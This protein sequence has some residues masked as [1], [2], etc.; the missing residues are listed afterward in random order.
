MIFRNLCITGRI[1]NRFTKDMGSVDEI[2]PKIIL[3]SSQVISNINNQISAMVVYLQSFRCLFGIYPHTS[4][5]VFQ[6]ILHL[7]GAV[8]LTV[9]TNYLLIFPL[10][11]MLIFFHFI[12]KFYLKTSKELK[13]ME[14]MGMYTLLFPPPLCKKSNLSRFALL[15]VIFPSRMINHV[16]EQGFKTFLLSL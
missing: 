7:C 9:I 3:D 15:C 14:G 11:F 5:F 2:L 16:N 8:V 6:M 4:H 12:Q 13:R 1:L 10:L